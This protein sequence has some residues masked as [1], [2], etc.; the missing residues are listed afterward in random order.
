[1]SQPARKQEYRA[2]PPSLEIRDYLDGDL[3]QEM[4][5]D[6][7]QGLSGGSKSLPPKYFYDELGSCLFE[8]IC[9]TPEYYP[10]RVEM[11]ILKKYAA[12]IMDF[13]GDEESD[14]VEL[15]S[16]S[17]RKVRTLLDAVDPDL[18]ELIRYVPLEISQSALRQSALELIRDYQGLRVL[19]LMA[20]FTRHLDALP[21][22]RKLITFLGG[23][24]GNF[25]SAQAVQLLSAVAEVM[26]PR[27]RFILGL[28][29]VKPVDVLERA[30]NDAAGVTERFNLN[31][32]ANINRELN[33]DLDPSD[34]EH[35][36][37][38]NRDEE[39]IEMHLKAVRPVQGRIRDLDL[40][41]RMK[42]GQTIHT[43]ISRKFTEDSASKEFDQAG[44]KPLRWMR[45]Q[46]GW[47]SLVEL[48]KV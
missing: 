17:N 29:M 9:E 35:L 6:A 33:G 42:P 12:S 27:D 4:I 10:T 26:G 44:L 14:L 45:D 3:R 11:G 41:L 23:S 32:L 39:Q 30:Y 20:D 19:G 36:A 46:Q 15:G 43:E 2:Q 47:F 25:S 21:R 34:F 8:D 7:R 24:I 1:L 16:G 31:I 5:R 38:F 18:L 22:G 13:F 40:E 28:D 48:A 37:F